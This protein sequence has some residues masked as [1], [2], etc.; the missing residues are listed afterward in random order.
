MSVMSL[1]H[2]PVL[3]PVFAGLIDLLEQLATCERSTWSRRT[4]PSAPSRSGRL[5]AQ[6]VSRC[7]HH[8]CMADDRQRRERTRGRDR[9]TDQ[10]VL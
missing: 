1:H 3:E 4:D 2:I 8:V 7:T 10:L 6:G 5:H 9:D